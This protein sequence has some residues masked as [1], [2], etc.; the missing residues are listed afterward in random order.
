MA[1][2]D[3]IDEPVALQDHDPGWKHWFVVERDRIVLAAPPDTLIEHFGST[4]VPD[5]LAKPIVDILVGV[6]DG[7]PLG[8][9]VTAIGELGY[10]VLGEAGVPGR[11]HLR[12]RGA[13]S[14]NVSVVPL[15]SD[16]WRDNLRFRDHLRTNQEARQRYAGAKR[17]AVDAG[18]TSLLDY[19]DFKSATV[20]Q[21]IAESNEVT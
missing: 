12:R 7:E 2:H 20:R 18:H 11:I 4:A 6:P 5:L 14:F 9:V 19:S 1:G 13:R 8:P 3:P 10:E 21:L 17:R 16:L 15:E